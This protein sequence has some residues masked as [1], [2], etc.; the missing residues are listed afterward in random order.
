VAAD[1]YKKRVIQLGEDPKRIFNVGGLG[2]DAIKKTKLL[3][4]KELIKNTGIQFRKKNL[5]V[6]YHPV[7]LE[8]ETS[9]KHFQVLLDVLQ[10]L[11]NVHLIF[12]MPN[13]D[14]D[15]RIIKQMIDEFVSRNNKRSI[16]FTSLGHLNYLSALQFVDGIV[17]NS[18]SGLV[19]APTFKVGTL[20]I[21]HRQKGR[22]KADSVI[23]CY[24]EKMSI[25]A[26][27][28]KLYS[29][30]FQDKLKTVKNPYGNG[31]GSNRIIEILKNEE[32]P[33]EIKKQFYDA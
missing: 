7:T 32:L 18:S 4:K 19:E 21:G 27:I 30:D 28:E 9:E 22:L 17:G 13:S 2:V 24:P 1:E 16:A 29:K 10:G 12:T 3:S 23:D 8:N 26:A 11:K 6:T 31:E 14:S 5:L 25:T 15:G 20:N 33:K